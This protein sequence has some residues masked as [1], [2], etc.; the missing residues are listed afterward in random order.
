ME[1]EIPQEYLELDQKLRQD[2]LK[3]N[4]KAKYGTAGFRDLSDNMS[5][6][7]LYFMVR[8]HLELEPL[9]VF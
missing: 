7:Y 8:S 5:Y 6:V 3:L 1:A 9:F 2:F 4:K